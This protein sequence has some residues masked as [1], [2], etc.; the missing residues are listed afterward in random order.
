MHPGILADIERA[1]KEL[2]LGEKAHEAARLKREQLDGISERREAINADAEAALSEAEDWALLESAFHAT[3]IPYML[4]RR[5][6]PAYEREVNRLLAGSHL[7]VEIRQGREVGTGGDKKTVDELFLTFTDPRGT[8]PLKIAS[9]EQRSSLGLPLRAALAKVGSE[10]WGRVPEIF[11]QD[12]GFGAFHD[13]R[14]PLALDLIARISDSFT[15]F[16]FITHKDG[17]ADSADHVITVK[18]T[19]SGAPEISKL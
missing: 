1:Q 4:M 6:V 3:G 17:L 5:V 2:S 15:R 11:V 8:F 12:E 13:D 9:G 14:L 16:V 19:S 18:A 7:S 10:F